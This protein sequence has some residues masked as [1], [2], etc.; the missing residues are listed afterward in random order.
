MKLS[1]A[2]PVYNVDSSANQDGAISEVAELLLRYNG[3]LERA[4]FCVTRSKDPIPDYVKMFGQVFSEEGFA[5]LPNRKPWDHA[6]E[7]VPGAQPKGCKVYPLSVTEQAELDNFLTENLK[8]GCIRPS[9]FP[10]ASPVFF[11]KK[12]DGSLRLVQDY[13]ML[14]E[15]TVKNKYPLPLISE[16]VNQ[17][18]GA[19]YFTKLDVCWGFNNV[20]IEEG[21]EW[22][23]AFRTNRGLFEPL[24]MFFGLMNSPATFQ[25][26]MNDIF[27]DMISE[28]V[29]VVY[30]DD[31]LIF[32]KD[33]DKHRRIT[34]RVLGRL[35]EHELYLRPEKCEF[36]K[37]R[38]EYL[39]LII[40][41]NRVE[42]DPVKVAGVAEWP[43]P[44]SK[45]EV[46]SFL[47]FV[48]FYR[49]FVKD[50]S[51]HARPL[52]DLTR[53][54]QKWKWDSPEASAFR[55]LKELVTSA[56]VLITPGDDQPFRVEADSSDYATGAVL[57]QLSLEDG[58][59]HPVAFLSK[60]LSE[61]EWNYE[62]H[63]KE[64]LAIMRALDE[65]RHFLEGAPHKV[66]IWT[67]HKNLEYFMSAKKLN[68]R[69]A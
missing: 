65:W 66:E 8:T 29:V 62:I 37:T 12:K 17:L 54:E 47:G 43:E 1:Q 68:R 56:P 31:I 69:Q 10:M 53:K 26:M 14:N 6:I 63:D 15:M 44:T 64:M 28:G 24:V 13:W 45:Q 36:K 4:L 58:K 39:G 21:D 9:K 30:L 3:H 5:K 19:K 34:Q 32:T 25:T 55:K 16:L 18:R 59:W 48:N 41:E 35:A 23:A 51:H 22:K 52:F 38:I 33:L 49:R 11:I 46:R 67:D 61:T 27:S 40:S 20:R 60:S 7:L 57:S 42:M 2:V 50:F